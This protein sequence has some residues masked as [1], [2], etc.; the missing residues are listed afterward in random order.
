MFYKMG[1]AIIVVII[2]FLLMWLIIDYLS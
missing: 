2:V 1:F